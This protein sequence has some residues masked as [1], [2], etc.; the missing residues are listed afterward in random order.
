MHGNVYPQ[1]VCTF[2]RETIHTPNGLCGLPYDAKLSNAHLARGRG[3]YV[4]LTHILVLFPA[5]VVERERGI[6]PYI[7][8]QK[9]ASHSTV[10]Y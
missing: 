2:Q 3:T 5:G 9:A 7:C 10:P 1:G 4:L 8:F 6:A